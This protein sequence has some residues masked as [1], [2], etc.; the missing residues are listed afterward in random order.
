VLDVRRHVA[1]EDPGVVGDDDGAG[2]ELRLEL[3]EVVEIVFLGGV[4]EGEVEAS[5]QEREDPQRVAYDDPDALAEAGD[6]G[7]ALDEL[8]TTLTRRPRPA[9]SALLLTNFAR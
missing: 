4:D 8:T 9:T 5:G 6:L 7:V 1:A 2:H 3:A